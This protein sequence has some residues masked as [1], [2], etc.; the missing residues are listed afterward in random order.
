[1]EPHGQSPWYRYGPPSPK[2]GYGETSAKE[3]RVPSRRSPF[4]PSPTGETRGT[5]R[6]RMDDT[7]LFNK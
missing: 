3:S 5:R 6:R 2:D 4:A 7:M 1:M